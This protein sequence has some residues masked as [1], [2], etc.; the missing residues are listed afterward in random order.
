M[1]ITRYLDHP[2]AIVGT[3]GAGKTF[4]AKSAVEQLLELGRRVIVIDP[5][6]AWWGLRSGADGSENGGFPVLIFGGEHA[7]VPI[8]PDADTGKALALALA[9]RDVQAIIDTSEM[10]H[11]EKN[12]FL[13]PFLENLYAKNKTA[14][15]LIVDEA[16]EIASQRLA[17]GEQRLFGAFDKIVRRGRI[18]G[19]RPVMI[20]QRPAVIHKNVLSQIGTLIALKLTSPQDRKAIEEWVKGN[21][22]ADQARA[23]MGSLPKLQRGEGWVWSPADDELELVKFLPIRTFDSSRTPEVGETVVAPALTGVDVAALRQMMVDAAKAK[24]EAAKPVKS[25]AAPADIE[26]AEKRGYDRGEEKGYRTG[27]GDGWDDA[28]IKVR[29]AIENIAPTAGKPSEARQRVEYPLFAGSNPTPVT[30]SSNPPLSTMKSKTREAVKSL[31]SAAAKQMT[32]GG[33]PFLDVAMRVWPAKLTWAGLAAACGRKARGGSFNTRRRAL[34][35]SGRVREEGDLVVPTN[36]PAAPEGLAP[37]DLLEQNLPTPS[38]DAFKIIRRTPGISIDALAHQLG[39]VPRGGSWN[40]RMSILRKNSLIS[41]A[42]GL[43]IAAGLE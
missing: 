37:A 7:D 34:L 22:D 41:E 1:D 11:G 31:A 33:D 42:G 28:F 3:T 27:Y 26:A 43:R 30:I 13:T 15:H 35:D 19:F 24:E 6:G 18:K 36:P 38:A 16:D 21:A 10:T 29:G 39:V 25:T 40:T 20:S 9:E 23:V 12:R 17:D 32:L 14:L 4:T 2:T 8:T 5:T